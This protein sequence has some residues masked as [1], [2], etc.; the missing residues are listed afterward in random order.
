MTPPRG[1]CVPIRETLGERDGES[2]SQWVFHHGAAMSA[3]DLPCGWRPLTQRRSA[4][5]RGRRES[6]ER[7]LEAQSVHCSS[8]ACQRWRVDRSSAASAEAIAC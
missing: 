6:A 7:A 3:P 5:A 8:N 2:R 4:V 1:A